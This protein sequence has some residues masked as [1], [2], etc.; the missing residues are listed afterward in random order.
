MEW[1]G[2]ISLVL[3]IVVQETSIAKMAESKLQEGVSKL[4]VG[5]IHS[6]IHLIFSIVLVSHNQSINQS[7]S[8]Q[9]FRNYIENNG[10]PRGRGGRV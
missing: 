10:F 8:G 4:Q 6:F 9:T 3:C 5:H 2:V 7:D 1:S